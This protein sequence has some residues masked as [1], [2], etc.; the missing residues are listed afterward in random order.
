MAEDTEAITGCVKIVNE[1][2]DDDELD[3][4]ITEDSSFKDLMEFYAER[5]GLPTC[6]LRFYFNG[7]RLT[8]EMTPKSL[9]MED[10]DIIEVF[11]EQICGNSS[12]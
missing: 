3:F 7:K 10:D 4:Q 9:N 1:K 11:K 5:T 12:S 8:Y 6:H 2:L